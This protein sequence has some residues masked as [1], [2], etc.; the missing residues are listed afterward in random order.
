MQRAAGLLRVRRESSAPRVCGQDSDSGADGRDLLVS[1]D[2][3][4]VLGKL[5]PLSEPHF[6]ICKIG[7]IITMLVP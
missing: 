2:L 1:L 6:F 5:L 3:L 4:C 7:I